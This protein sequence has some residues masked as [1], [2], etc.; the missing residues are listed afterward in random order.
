M[1]HTVWFDGKPVNCALPAAVHILTSITGGGIAVFCQI[2][3][4][5][6]VSLSGAGAAAKAVALCEVCAP[7]AGA[8]CG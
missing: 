2:G 5:G 6:L 3:C 8:F 7:G 4:N 1:G